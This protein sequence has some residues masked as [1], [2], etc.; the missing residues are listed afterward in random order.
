VRDLV[1]FFGGNWFWRSWGDMLYSL[2]TGKTA[3]DHVFGMTNFAY[4]EHNAEVG[5]LHDA[6]FTRMADATTPALVA[7]YDYGQFAKIADVGGSE[8][9]LLA[10]ILAAY[11]NVRGLLFDLPHVVDG[12]ERLLASAG[13]ADRCEQVGGNFFESVP[14]GADAYILKQVL[15]DWDDEHCDS[16]LARCRE[17]MSAGNRLLVIELVMPEAWSDS[18]AALAAARIDLAM[19][20]HTTGGRERTE[21]EFRELFSSCGFKLNQVIPTSSQF[22]ILEA[23]AV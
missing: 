15:H 2:E 14:A 8:G 12:A 6:S 3:F 4:W 22:S 16:V 17:A 1:L 11:P 23:F 5:A 20:L 19:L 18:V 13:V 21:A 10:A 9:P 7:A